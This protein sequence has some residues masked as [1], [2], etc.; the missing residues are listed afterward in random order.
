MKTHAQLRAKLDESLADERIHYAPAQ[1]T[2]NTP[3]ALIQVDLTA[4]IRTLEWVLEAKP[5]KLM[6]GD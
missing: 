6:E 1:V 5:T 2:I 4:K 3:L